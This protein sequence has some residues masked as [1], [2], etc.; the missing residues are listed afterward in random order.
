M[1]KGQLDEAI[2][3]FRKAIE[4]DPKNAAA[5][6]A[7]GNCL[8][9]KGQSDEAIAC[10]QKAIELDP[11]KAE[12]HSNL[13]NALWPRA[14]WTRPS[15]APQGHR[16]RPEA[17]RTHISSA[18]RCGKGQLDEAIAHF[19]KAI[20]LDPKLASAH[21]SLGNALLAKGQLDEAMAATRR[22]SNSTRRARRL[23]KY[24]QNKAKKNIAR[25]A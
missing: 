17:R 24:K 20:E 22:P 2:A 1:G 8:H 19:R 12:A 3:C 23:M 14:S 4:L 11:K 7:L 5:H 21:Y 13:G 25:Y 9:A 18:T 6:I 16:T 15:P 10:Y